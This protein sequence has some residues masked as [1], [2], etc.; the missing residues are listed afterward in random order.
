[1]C[2]IFIHNFSKHANPLVHLTHKGTPFKFGPAQIAAQ[3]DLRKALLTSPT[4][5]PIDYSS[6]SPVILAVDT[7]QTAVGFYLCQEDS[8]NPHKRYFARFGLI[9]LNEHERQFSQPKLELYGLFRTLRAYKIFIV[10][11]RNLIVEVDARYIKG[12]L[13]N[14]DTAPSTS[15]NRWIISVLTFHFNLRHV[16]GKQHGPDGLSRHLPQPG[17]IVTAKDKDGFDDWV[18]SLYSFMHLINHPMPALRSDSLLGALIE[19]VQEKHSNSS[20]PKKAEPDYNV[21]PRTMNAASVDK[22]L[23]QVH[24][25]LTFTEQPEDMS[26]K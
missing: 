18:D 16:P 2:R 15:I 12:M 10:G 25:W 14:P 17:D 8:D 7:S 4:L 3:E 24:D 9:T 13:N 11:V 23:E 26:D 21:I 22:H 20:E 1:M 6:D 19:D 5:R